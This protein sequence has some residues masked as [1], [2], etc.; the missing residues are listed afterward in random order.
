ML[1]NTFLLLEISDKQRVTCK[2]KKIVL[3]LLIKMWKSEIRGTIVKI[4]KTILRP[5]YINNEI[6]FVETCIVHPKLCF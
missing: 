4:W 2:S 1:E 6:Y 3:Y 5:F